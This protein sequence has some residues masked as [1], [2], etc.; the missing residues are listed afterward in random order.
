MAAQDA[1]RWDAK[2]RGRALPTPGPSAALESVA[3]WIPGQGRLLDLAGG[4]GAQAVWL[5]AR[6]LEVTLCDVSGVALE[7]AKRVAAASGQSLTT[8][9]ID[10]E[11]VPLPEGPW[12]AVV[13]SN[14]LQL[15]LWP[16]VASALR[17]GG[18]AIWLH[19]TIENLTRHEKPS[20]RFLL[21][22]GQGERVIADAGLGV[23]FTE[24]SWVA[25]RHL[26]CVVGSRGA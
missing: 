22:P 13:C 20:R 4:D 16:A 1:T 8:L 5:A 23:E 10:L 6:G 24:E 14:Y 17:P 21:E 12:S 18:R 15:S 25:G 11:I 9:Q 3:S 7:R 26:S 19:P 2:Y